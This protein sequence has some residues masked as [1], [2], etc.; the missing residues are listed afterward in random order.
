MEI[1]ENEISEENETNEEKSKKEKIIEFFESTLAYVIIIGIAI[2]IRTFVVTP[3]QVDGLSM[4]STL[5]DNE[6]LIL[7]KYDK[8]FSR[9]D[10]IVFKHNKS[11]LIKRI[12]GLPGDTLE[13]K[14]NKLYIN[15]KYVKEKFLT[16]GQIT[17]DFSLKD[18]GY[19]K[20]PE[21]YY[22]VMGDNRTNSIDSRVFGLV[23]KEEIYGT[24]NFAVFP[25]DKFGNINK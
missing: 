17:S 19:E 14:N 6:I 20:I 16:N 8:S 1:E 9:F 2:L 24:T 13:Y 25:L 7:K 15:G 18:Y 23:S 11:R 5:D 4:Y 3:V 21:G 10:V 12:I 22:F